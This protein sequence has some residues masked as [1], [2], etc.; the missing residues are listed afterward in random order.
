MVDEVGSAVSAFRKG[1][2]VII[3]CITACGKCDFC[4]R[5]MYSHCR[6][7]GWILGNTIDGTQAEYV[8]IPYADTSLYA[9]PADTEKKQR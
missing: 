2:K 3:S 8:L 9:L 6:N 4:R 5:Q 7:G 1:D